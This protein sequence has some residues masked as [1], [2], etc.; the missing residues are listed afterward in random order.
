MAFGV[1]DFHDLV[2]LLEQHPE[3]RADLRRLLLSDEILS[4]PDL[5]RDLVEGQK[6]TDESVRQLVQAQARTDDQIRQLTA[7][8]DDLTQRLEQ[9]TARVDDLTQRLEQLTARVDDLTQR[10]EQLTAR[11]DDLTQRLEQLTEDV[12]E[13]G[14]RIEQLTASVDSLTQSVQR[15][16]E[17]VAKMKEFYLEQRYYQRAPAYFCRIIRRVRPISYDDLCR[18]LDDAMDQGTLTEAERDDL[19]E[20]D[21][22][23][24]GRKRID[25]E[26]VYLIVEVS[27][28]IGTNDVA[29]AAQWARTFAK[30]GWKTLPVVAGGWVNTDA[31]E[32]ARQDGVIVLL[33][34]GQAVDA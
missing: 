33:D 20:T 34:G 7:R 30:L 10:L 22:V 28:G 32:A 6:L 11:V 23:V 29:R 2:S 25:G 8:V 19:I 9:L 27:W 12:R 3:W 15:I 5:V 13:L 14:R 21:V 17:D 18:I 31:H 26:E 1:T 4:L 24:Y 16:G